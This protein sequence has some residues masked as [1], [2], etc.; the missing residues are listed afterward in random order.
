M[1][2]EFKTITEHMPPEIC[3]PFNYILSENGEPIQVF[4]LTRKWISKEET[5]ELWY[6]WSS[7]HGEKLYL[8]AD[9]TMSDCL[10]KMHEIYEKEFKI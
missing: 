6:I 7:L 8:L 10:K 3:P 4:V 2:F 9:E 5:K 1:P